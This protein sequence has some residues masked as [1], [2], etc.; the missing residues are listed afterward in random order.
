M[1]IGPVVVADFNGDG[2]LDV[3]VGAYDFFAVAR[4]NGNL[5]FQPQQVF[6]ASARPLTVGTGVNSTSVS[7]GIAVGDFQK[8]GRSDVV[9]TSGLGVARLYNVTPK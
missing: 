5:T 3:G 9:L 4:G 8:S 6:A 1:E 7:N 2:K